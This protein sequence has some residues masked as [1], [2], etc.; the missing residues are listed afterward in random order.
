MRL[1]LDTNVLIWWLED[2]KR[3]STDIASLLRDPGNQVFVSAVSGW[4]IAIKVAI[5]KLSAPGRPADWLPPALNAHG[6][7]SLSVSLEHGLAVS[8][9]P[10][11]H[12][13]PFDRLL[14]AQAKLERLTLVSGD[15]ALAAY[16]VELISV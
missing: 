14:I 6:F 4:E 12:T 3:L 1:L 8:D 10:M 13:D 2:A 11:H 15:G 5:G 7:A 16:G 9:L